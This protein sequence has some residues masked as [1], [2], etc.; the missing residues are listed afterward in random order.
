MK[1]SI[2][3]QS[4][5]KLHIFFNF[6]P[7]R[8][9][10]YSCYKN[11]FFSFLTYQ[12]HEFPFLVRFKSLLNETCFDWSLIFYWSSSGYCLFQTIDAL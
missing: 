5:N 2:K 8:H 3:I 9:R 6:M 7:E 12:D 10:F 11:T 1:M 4:L